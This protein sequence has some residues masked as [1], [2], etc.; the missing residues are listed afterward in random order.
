[1]GDIPIKYCGYIGGAV[2]QTIYWDLIMGDTP[3]KY[4]GY[5]GG[6]IWQTIYWDFIKIIP[7]GHTKN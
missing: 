2:W 1:M 3:I 4:C 6:A 5:I 7:F